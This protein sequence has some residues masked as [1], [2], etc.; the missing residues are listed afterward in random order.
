MNK[1]Q[2]TLAEAARM[3]ADFQKEMKLLPERKRRTFLRYLRQQEKKLTS[4]GKKKKEGEEGDE[5]LEPEE[6]VDQGNAPK[7]LHDVHH[8]AFEK[9]KGL[10]EKYGRGEDVGDDFEDL[11]DF[12]ADDLDDLDL[13]DEDDEEDED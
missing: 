4:T 13:N 3:E 5:E 8:A 7:T 10:R 1:P 2:P 12:D 6:E 9:L 11:E